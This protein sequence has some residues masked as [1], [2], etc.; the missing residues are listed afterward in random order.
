MVISIRVQDSPIH[1][2]GVYADQDIPKGKFIIE[3]T[4]ERL[5]LKEAEEAEKKATNLGLN[6]LFTLNN[7]ITIDGSKTGNTAK[8]INHSCDPNCE[9]G[10]R[11]R[12]E[13]YALRKIKKGEELFYDYNFDFQGKLHSCTCGSEKCRGF[14]EDPDEV[15]KSLLE[16]S[17]DRKV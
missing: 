13:I 6:Y 8:F 7:K 3:Y 1:G 14:I 15:P 5:G 4:G 12:L 9:V 16:S 17:G 11:A 2:K 10:G